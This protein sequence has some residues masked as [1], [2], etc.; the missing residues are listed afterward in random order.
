M[1]VGDQS[2]VNLVARAS[3]DGSG[4]IGYWVGAGR[5]E[6]FRDHSR[7][8]ITELGILEK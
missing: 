7:R 2:N 6:D 3:Y 1:G 5:L 8:L 4:L